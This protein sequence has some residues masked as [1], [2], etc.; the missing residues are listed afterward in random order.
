MKWEV[1][2]QL[3][4]GGK[5]NEISLIT[6]TFSHV[7]REINATVDSLSKEGVQLEAGVWLVLES[8]DGQVAEHIKSIYWLCISSAESVDIY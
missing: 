7:Y 4:W 5:S 3:F 8:K 6:Y 1:C 2:Y